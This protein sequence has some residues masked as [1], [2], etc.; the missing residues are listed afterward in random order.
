[1]DLIGI[2]VKHNTWGLG[3]V[4]EFDGE[5]LSVEFPIGVKRFVYPDAFERFLKAEREDIQ[6]AIIEEIKK[7]TEEAE[8]KRQIEDDARKMDVEKR[9][10]VTS[11]SVP[12]AQKIKSLDEMFPPDYHVEKMARE[13][14]LTYQQVEEQFGIRISGPGRGINPTDDAVVLI[15]SIR[16]SGG[17]FVYHDKWTA[18]GD[19]IYSGEGRTGDQTMTRGNLA[20]KNA[21]SDGKSIHLFIKFSPQEYYYQ[22]VFDLVDYTYEDEK[23]EAGNIRKEYKFRLRKVQR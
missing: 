7:S 15:S 14:I 23:D 19:Y 10:T 21:A 4:I 18:D 9:H 6:A 16:K 3:T 8:Q 20:I 2:T 17:N 12:K 22:G 11:T 13:P 5:H 1:M